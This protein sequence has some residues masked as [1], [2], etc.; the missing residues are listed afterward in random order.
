MAGVLVFRQAPFA[1]DDELYRHGAANRLFCR[2]GDGLVKCVGVQAV[3]V[4]V[5][6][7]QGLQ[8]GADIVELNFLR[9]QTATACLYV[10]L[11]FLAAVI[12][13]VLVT[14]GDGPYAPCNATQHRVLGVHPVAE[15][16][17]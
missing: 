15:E 2:R 13:A 3:A 8:G 4:V 10:V 7:D 11:Q 14:Q 16:E 17:R 12:G 6:S 1:V 5:N 9:M